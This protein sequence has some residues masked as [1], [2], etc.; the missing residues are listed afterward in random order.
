MQRCQSRAR[1]DHSN[2]DFCRKKIEKEKEYALGTTLLM[3]EGNRMQA[4]AAYKFV[5]A[6][7]KSKIPGGRAVRSQ[8]CSSLLIE[9]EE[10]Q[11]QGYRTSQSLSGNAM[12]HNPSC[13]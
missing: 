7:V 11:E 9:G 5:K 1:K 3:R 4:T 10:E 12:T 13:Y 6:V 8:S 2:Q